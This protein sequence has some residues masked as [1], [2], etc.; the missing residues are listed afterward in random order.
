ML[1]VK[2]ASQ[3]K[4]LKESDDLIAKMTVYVE[5]AKANGN[6]IGGVHLGDVLSVAL[7]GFVK[8]NAPAIAKATG[9][10][11]LAGAFSNNTETNTQ[12]QEN[13]E[14]SFKKKESGNSPSLSEKEKEFIILF[15]EL[16][17]CFTQEEMLQIVGILQCLNKDKTQLIPVLE[18]L[19]EP[20]E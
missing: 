3:D 17:K 20:S 2:V 9:F 14:A 10:E 16:E 5:Q 13:S 1:R 11:G 6:K 12:T 7:E 18:L 15:H 8:R 19:Q 4:K